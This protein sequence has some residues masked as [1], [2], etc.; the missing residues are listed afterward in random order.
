MVTNI[1]NTALNV[2]Q[3][4]MNSGR[5]TSKYEVYFTFYLISF[6]IPILFIVLPFLT[7]KMV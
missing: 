1:L 7:R 3:L 4:N 5:K 6:K 2:R